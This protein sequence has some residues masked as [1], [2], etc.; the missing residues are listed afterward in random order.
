M[1]YA[2]RHSYYT[3][4]TMKY[5]ESKGY[6]V[7]K[8][9]FV[10]SFNGHY[11]KV[12]MWGSDFAYKNGNVLGFVQVKTSPKQLSVGRKQLT[13]NWPSSVQRWVS[14]WVPRAKEPTFYQVDNGC[15]YVPI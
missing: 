7:F 14:Y 12:D 4:K 8:T 9:E 5:L 10:T 6:D 1:N 11:S 3:A 15:I 2:R 13:G